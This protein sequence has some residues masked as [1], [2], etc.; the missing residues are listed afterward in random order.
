MYI[1]FDLFSPLN[2]MRAPLVSFFFLLSSPSLLFSCVRCGERV[3]RR[4]THGRHAELAAGA[5]RGAR[6]LNTRGRAACGA[7]ILGARGVRGA[8]DLAGALLGIPLTDVVEG[9]RA[10]VAC[11]NSRALD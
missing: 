4:R 3:Q 11:K 7:R 5:A 1:S 2:D 8:R 6:G 9:A 10:S